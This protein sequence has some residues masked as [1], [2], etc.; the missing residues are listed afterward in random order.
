VRC[1]SHPP[2]PSTQPISTSSASSS[3]QLLPPCP[4]SCF[5]SL[6]SH[7]PA[8]PHSRQRTWEQAPLP[9]I[10]PTPASTSTRAVAIARP[11]GH[12][13]AC[14]HYR[15]HHRRTSCSSSQSSPCSSSPTCC[16]THGHSH[17]PTDARRRGYGR[18]GLASGLSPCVPPRK[19]R[20]CLPRLGYLGDEESRSE[21]LNSQGP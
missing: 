18:I 16:P 10:C 4:P 14:T 9:R 3:P 1:T 17:E 12:F 8:P 19:I 6:S 20:W 21:I 7:A 5:F 2:I 11:Q 15:F 13:T